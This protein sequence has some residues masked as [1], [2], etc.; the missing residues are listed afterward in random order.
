M[1]T[2]PLKKSFFLA[3]ACLLAGSCGLKAQSSPSTSHSRWQVGV[4]VNPSLGFA[5]VKPNIGSEENIAAFGTDQAILVRYKLSGHFWL[6]AGVGNY[7]KRAD[8]QHTGIRIPELTKERYKISYIGIPLRLDYFY[9]MNTRFRPYV[10]IGITNNFIYSSTLSFGDPVNVFKISNKASRGYMPSS[11]A[12]IGCEVSLNSR[13]VLSLQP[14]YQQNL[15]SVSRWDD[16]DVNRAYLHS[17]GLN[18]GLA[19]SF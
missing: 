3:L 9:S 7:N 6:S 14:D 2:Q 1:M 17:F 11:Y 5:T 10:S 18:T 12:G 16:I 4:E 19:Y 8:F 13:L 15:R